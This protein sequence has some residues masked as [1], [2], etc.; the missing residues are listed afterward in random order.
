[1]GF[2]SPKFVDPAGA[3]AG[4]GGGGG[5]GSAAK[6]T[7][8]VEMS[9]D[10]ADWTVIKSGFAAVSPEPTLEKVGNLLVADFPILRN[11]NLGGTT[12]N[13][14]SMISKQHILPW[15]NHSSGGPPGSIPVQ[16][17][18]PEAVNIKIEVRFDDANG[19]WN[20]TGPNGYGYYMITVAGLVSYQTDQ[21]GAPG[22]PGWIYRGASIRK[23]TS[24]EPSAVSG[25]NKFRGGYK[26]YFGWADR[27]DHEYKCQSGTPATGHDSLVFSAGTNLRTGTSTANAITQAGTYCSTDL[28]GPMNQSGYSFQ[29]GST[30]YANPSNNCNF[31]HFWIFF[32][33][34]VNNRAG[35]CKINRIRYCIQPL[36][37]RTDT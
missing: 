31:F 20:G 30:V 32:G 37:S 7:E 35:V 21:G 28:F 2:D 15:S 36:P 1:M 25:T 22:L 8:W 5:G 16:Q 18:Q 34:H 11:F 12:N 23:T 29:D 19:P 13:G 17:V 14:I 4:G 26:T 33:S 10:P 9:L 27:G 6:A 24:L 3:E